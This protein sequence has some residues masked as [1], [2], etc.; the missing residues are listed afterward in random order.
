MSRFGFVLIHVCVRVSHVSI[1]LNSFW[2]V[3]SDDSFLQSVATIT[4]KLLSSFLLI[5][6]TASPVYSFQN[7]AVCPKAAAAATTTRLGS[8]QVIDPATSRAARTDAMPYDPPNY[9]FNS[10]IHSFGNTGLLGGLH[11]ALAP[12]A[13]LLIDRAAYKGKNVRQTVC[14]GLRQHMGRISRV[15]DLCSGVGISTRALQGAFPDAQD[16]VGV[17]TSPEMTGMAKM[18]STDSL[19]ARLMNTYKLPSSSLDQHGFPASKCQPRFQIGNAEQTGLAAGSYDLVTIM[20]AFHE[21]PFQGRVRMLHEAHRLLRKG[22]T[23]AIVDISPNYI[24]SASMLAGEPYVLEYQTNI[25][26]QLHETKGFG[27]VHYKEMIPGHVSVWLL[28]KAGSQ[29]QVTRPAFLKV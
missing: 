25:D 18:L 24:P 20:Y 23:V 9:W 16:I 6:V 4:M 17:D 8:S 29:R 5:L 13:T 19:F 7:N 22:G 2:P 28:T 3:C 14:E 10:R 21:A 26:R 1:S 12:L 27:H 15:A 11:A